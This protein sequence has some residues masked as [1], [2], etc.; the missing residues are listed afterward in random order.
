MKA[1]VTSAPAGHRR[2]V[3]TLAGAVVLA[4]ALT[5]AAVVT[6]GTLFAG[7]GRRPAPGAP[8]TS[9]WSSTTRCRKPPCV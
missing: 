8:A 7:P 9:P 6:V 1:P 4:L 2:V 3:R 5:G